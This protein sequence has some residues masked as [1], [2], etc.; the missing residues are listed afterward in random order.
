MKLA[1][2]RRLVRAG[3]ANPEKEDEVAKA[4]VWAVARTVGG[5]FLEYDPDEF[6]RRILECLELRLNEHNKERMSFWNKDVVKR[7]DRIY[8]PEEVVDAFKKAWNDVTKAIKMETIK[9]L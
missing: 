5:D 8:T 2:L 9:V 6:S 1:V 4:D 3:E 7:V